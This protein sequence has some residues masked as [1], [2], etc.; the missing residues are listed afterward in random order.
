MLIL[1]L[2]NFDSVTAVCGSFWFYNLFYIG[3]PWEVCSFEKG[4]DPHFQ[5]EVI[6]LMLDIIKPN[7]GV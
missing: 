2:W 6:V 3:F 4:R 7:T 1:E 5:K